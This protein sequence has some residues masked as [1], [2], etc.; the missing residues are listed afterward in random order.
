MNIP[1]CVGMPRS[2]SRM[3]WQIVKHLAP[4]TPPPD[5]YPDLVSDWT[6]GGVGQWPL[7][8][9]AYLPGPP[10]VYTFRHPID[11]FLSLRSRFRT[12]VGKMVPVAEGFMTIAGE[13][14]PKVDPKNKVLYTQTQADKDA[15]VAIGSQWTVWKRL[16]EDS[17]GNRS[18]LFLKY[19][20]YAYNRM[21][22]IKDIA[23]FMDV[24]LSDDLAKEILD[25][26]AIEK[27]MARSR[28]PALYENDEVTFSHGF[29]CSSGMQKGHI[30]RS[31][32]GRPGAHL[33]SDPEFVLGILNE[34]SPAHQALKEMTEEMGYEVVI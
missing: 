24:P 30:N 21:Q 34:I 7:R 8:G 18:V 6:G 25:Y 2:A 28:N 23:E 20:D 33:E 15:M 22:E 17:N 14:V 31:T 32:M 13:E 9:H 10:V 19:E 26:T 3:A 27:N 29:M 16:V 4:P 11:A 1:V 12:D 5:Y